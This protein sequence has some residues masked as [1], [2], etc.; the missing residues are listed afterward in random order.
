MMSFILAITCFIY[1]HGQ[2]PHPSQHT[3]IIHL[4]KPKEQKKPRTLAEILQATNTMLAKISFTNQWNEVKKILIDT[5]L[6]GINPNLCCDK[7][8][9][10][11]LFYAIVHNDE[12]FARYLLK[13]RANAI[14][15]HE[16]PWTLLIEAPTSSMAQL[17]FECGADTIV[18]KE[19]T[20]YLNEIIYRKETAIDLI[21]WYLKKGVS[22]NNKYE[23]ITPLT[24]LMQAAA[25]LP[26]K[27]LHERVTLLMK[28]GA[29]LDLP[30]GNRQRSI[31]TIIQQRLAKTPQA[32]KEPY[33]KLEQ[34]LKQALID[35]KEFIKENSERLFSSKTATLIAD[36]ATEEYR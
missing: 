33:I 11:P 5:A 18:Q 8:G 2:M 7:F 34:M 13:N 36:Y 12:P 28:A 31:P 14:E 22:P 35:R 21:D 25:Y 20:R 29:L 19:G 26:E 32:K 6:R 16:E 3:L 23:D 30:V 9:E 1:L 15:Q 24:V 4:P 27:M 17:L 10:C